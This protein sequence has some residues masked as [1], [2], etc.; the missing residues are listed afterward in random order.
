MYNNEIIKLYDKV[1]IGTPVA[2]TNSENSFQQLAKIY[3]KGW[4]IK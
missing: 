3:G 1:Q 2:V 4:K